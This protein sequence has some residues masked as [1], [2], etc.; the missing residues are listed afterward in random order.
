[1]VR[2]YNAAEA[3]RERREFNKKLREQ[4]R[5]RGKFDPPTPVSIRPINID[6]ASHVIDS[7]IRSFR[8]SPTVGPVESAVFHIEQ[9]ARINRLISRSKTFMACDAV[10][11]KL[12][13][14]WIVFEPPK[15]AEHAPVV[16]FVCVHPSY[17]LQGIGTALVNLAKQTHPDPEAPMWC[18]HD[19]SPM[20]H[21]R[22]KWNLLYNP[23]LLELDY[24]Q[25]TKAQKGIAQGAMNFYGF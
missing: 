14:G 15:A 19:T 18:T 23:Y 21:I 17:Q 13:R 6:D 10:D 16:H 2:E 9:R 4:A 22:P 25:P 11:K 3:R 20:R 8:P 24:S 1:V 5:A 7:W 12:I